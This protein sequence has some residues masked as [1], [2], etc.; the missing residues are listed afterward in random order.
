MVA[1]G[2][3]AP[4][5]SIPL[6]CLWEA[7]SQGSALGGWPS[8]FRVEVFGE[9]IQWWDIRTTPSGA[10]LTQAIPFNTAVGHLLGS[11]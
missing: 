5:L 2:N 8:G 6:F 11:T 1:H 7:T 10:K 4:Q 9:T 3:Y